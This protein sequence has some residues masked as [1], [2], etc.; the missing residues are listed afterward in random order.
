MNQ[1][2]NQNE[3]ETLTQGYLEGSLTPSE[4]P[5]LLALL[6]EDPARVKLILA[7]L[8]TDALI[9]GVVDQSDWVVR[10][11]TA[12]APSADEILPANLIEEID[13]SALSSSVE[14]LAQPRRSTR[15]PFV[16]WS[17]AL[18][19]SV[20]FFVGL[21]VWLFPVTDNAPRLAAAPGT[22]VTLERGGQ[23][24]T[25][26]DAV[27][28]AAGDVLRTGD[29][30][31]S[32]A[33]TLHYG[34]ERTQISLFSGSELKV[35]NW[36]K[37]KR[38]ELREGKLEA[39]VARQRPFQPMRV[40]TPQAEARVLGTRFA[41]TVTTNSTRVDVTEGRVRLTRNSDDASVKVGAGYYAIAATNVVLSSL[42]Q[43]G[44]IL[45]EYW[46]N[47]PGSNDENETLLTMHEVLE[48][49][50]PPEMHPYLVC[51]SGPSFAKETMLK[52]PTAVVVASPW[53]KMAQRV[54]R[55]FSNDYFRVYTSNDVVGVELGGSL[56]NVCAI[57]A[58][59]SDG[60]GFGNNTR[61]AIMTRG[62]AELVRL[63]MRK[64]ANPITLSGLAGMGDL[65]VS[66]FHPSGRNRRAGELIARGATPHAARAHIGQAVEGLTTAPVLRDLSRRI[67][68]ELPITEGVCAV[69]EGMPLHELAG[70]LMGRRPTEE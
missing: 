33:I 25:V 24:T 19:A 58:G 62:L 1:S 21:S 18:A 17:L 22:R 10:T 65:M 20:A 38:L 14:T 31:G 16:R 54:Q 48:D 9:K 42:P 27:A 66:C 32:N 51:L 26:S 40:S 12:A 63:A 55:W 46:T 47:I 52:M 30:T 8:Q 53:E 41:L 68:V 67:G 64:G 7:N 69:V 44:A 23:A 6:K 57:A 61:A 34:R 13:F 35:L 28:L 39:S 60:M 43:T 15:R 45:R 50:L 11:S 70:S 49:V 36:G 56:K 29:A 5:R 37:G 2:T 3:V 4:S 59:I